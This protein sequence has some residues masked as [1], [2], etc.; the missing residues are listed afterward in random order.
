MKMVVIVSRN[1][2]VPSLPLA[3][4]TPQKFAGGNN[5]PSVVKF[6]NDRNELLP[7]MEDATVEF[8]TGRQH[9]GGNEPFIGVDGLSGKGL[10]AVAAMLSAASE[11]HDGS[12]TAT[13]HD[14]TDGST[15]A[16]TVH[17][18]HHTSQK[19]FAKKLEEAAHSVTVQTT[20]VVSSG[21][22]ADRAAHLARIRD[23]LDS[24]RV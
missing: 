19:F 21:V 15:F 2:N 4:D 24:T 18:L 3:P 10:R 14:A 6:I 12:Y 9:D 23:D 17:H 20:D 8:R 1:S 13:W 11:I 16:V 22:A 5:C 7:A